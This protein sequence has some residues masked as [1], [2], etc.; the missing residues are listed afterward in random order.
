MKNVRLCLVLFGAAALLGCRDKPTAPPPPP[1]PAAGL[2]ATIFRIGMSEDDVQ[3]VVRSVPN[4]R[5]P[6]G[7]V[8]AVV[9]AGANRSRLE[10][11]SWSREEN[12]PA[13]MRFTFEAR[14][15]IQA[16]LTYQAPDAATRGELYD[17]LLGGVAGSYARSTNRVLEWGGRTA[18]LHAPD[19]MLLVYESRADERAVIL[20]TSPPVFK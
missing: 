1:P 3:N 13:S 5:S 18:W 12:R 8:Y 16:E 10:A 6:D 4:Y 11:N 9:S 14:Q 17:R 20:R 19:H 2:E 15:L 7:A